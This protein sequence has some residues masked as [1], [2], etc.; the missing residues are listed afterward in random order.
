MQGERSS[1]T[2]GLNDLATCEWSL[3]LGAFVL[4]GKSY[5]HV[6]AQVLLIISVCELSD[7]L[8]LVQS[9]DLVVQDLST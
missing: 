9:I 4:I 6:L 5:D 1:R 8:R 2:S 7:V 3:R